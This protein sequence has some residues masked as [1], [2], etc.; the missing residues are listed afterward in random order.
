MKKEHVF[1]TVFTTAMIFVIFLLMPSL[2]WGSIPFD[3]KIITVV[4]ITLLNVI[5][6]EWNFSPKNSK[7]PLLT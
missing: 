3:I 1:A 7:P 4:P 6:C 2:I 5:F